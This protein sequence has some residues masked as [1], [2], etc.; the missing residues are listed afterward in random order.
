MAQDGLTGFTFD[1]AKVPAIADAHLYKELSIQQDRLILGV[2]DELPVTSYGLELTIGRGE[3]IVMG[4]M[5]KITDPITL[6]VPSLF[7]GYLVAEVDLAQYND[8]S[9]DIE[10]EDYKFTLNQATI[11]IVSTLT[12][13]S[14]VHDAVIGTIS[15]TS[16]S[17]NFT[18]DWNFYNS[19]VF[20]RSIDNIPSSTDKYGYGNNFMIGST[21][22]SN[23]D[24]SNSLMLPI[25]ANSNNQL[26]VDDTPAYNFD[27]ISDTG[28]FTGTLPVPSEVIPYSRL[29]YR[30]TQTR[31]VNRIFEKLYI[32]TGGGNNYEG[33]YIRWHG[34]TTWYPWQKI[35]T[36]SNLADLSGYTSG[37]WINVPENQYM[38]GNIQIAVQ[39]GVLTIGWGGN[40]KGAMGAGDTVV[41]NTAQLGIP[42]PMMIIRGALS[43]VSSETPHGGSFRW[44]TNGDITINLSSAIN[45]TSGSY[46]EFGGSG[47]S[48]T[49]FQPLANA[50]YNS[51]L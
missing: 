37:K 28:G 41:A 26:N 20:L 24:H 5:I 44:L 49:Q 12:D 11:K 7:Q 48:K 25:M 27:A 21:S 36:T 18:K 42:L 10:S 15:A 17:I 46:Y 51:S 4:R 23:D 13:T 30:W 22:N 9:G 50:Q 34:G 6:N 3:A 31:S 19:G 1:F 32:T 2:D 43:N 47:P 8:H 16:T 29:E 35:A 38:T 45:S 40:F 33:V 14:S 39:S